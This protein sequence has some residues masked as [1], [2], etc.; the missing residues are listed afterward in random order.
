MAK[1]RIKRQKPLQGWSWWSCRYLQQ[2]LMDCGE[3]RLHWC[4]FG[5][6]CLFTYFHHLPQQTDFFNFKMSF[7]LTNISLDKSPVHCRKLNSIKKV[8]FSSHWLYDS[9]FIIF[10]NKVPWGT[11]RK[12]HFCPLPPKTCLK[13]KLDFTHLTKKLIQKIFKVAYSQV[14]DSFVQLSIEGVLYQHWKITHLV[15]GESQVVKQVPCVGKAPFISIPTF[16]KAEALDFTEWPDFSGSQTFPMYM[17][18]GFKNR[19]EVCTD[20]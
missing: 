17:L 2:I 14:W 1:K 15:P 10:L 16:L 13:H 19:K 4:H 7:K 3:R 8:L 5:M 18:R 11:T 6:C 20:L 9:L 12:G